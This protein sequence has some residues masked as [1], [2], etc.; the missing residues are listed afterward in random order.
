MFCVVYTTNL[1]NEK[2]VKFN[3]YTNKFIQQNQKQFALKFIYFPKSFKL[4][5]NH[6][7]FVGLGLNINFPVSSQ[8]MLKSLNTSLVLDV[9][10]EAAT[11]LFWTP[12]NTITR[13]INVATIKNGWFAK[14]WENG[15]TRVSGSMSHCPAPTA[16]QTETTIKTILH[17]VVDGCKQA[18]TSVRRLSK[19]FKSSQFVCSKDIF[20]TLADKY[21]L[22]WCTV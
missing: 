2:F 12:S 1:R 11:T 15:T 20:K 4:V 6:V 16:T 7:K 3:W 10:I 17:L 8:D 14:E 9:I 19:A 13:N 5:W 22:D 21:Y 18:M